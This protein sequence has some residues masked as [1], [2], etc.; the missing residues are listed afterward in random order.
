M[1]TLNK[2]YTR[3]GDK[4]TT[5]LGNGDRVEKHSLRVTAYGTVDETNA[6]VGMARLHSDG[7]MDDAL[8]RIQND[9]FDI[10]ADLCRPD[11]D[12]DADA[13]YPPLRITAAQVDR[14]ESEIDAMNVGLDPLKSFI[15]PGG[16]PLAAH[17]HLCR[18]VSRRA[19]RLASELATGGD[20]TQAAVTYLNRLSDWFFVAS[21]VANGNGAAD[22]LWVPGK[23]R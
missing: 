16:S 5:A 17:L 3:T 9:L 7:E 23:T 10:G 6:T 15:L 18:T 1:V 22:V 4:G 21:R 12:K 2:I 14:L 13:E 19:E 11:I 8:A 20:V